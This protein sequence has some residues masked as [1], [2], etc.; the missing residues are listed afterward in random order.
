M[1]RT[2]VPASRARDYDAFLSYTRT[3]RRAAAGIQQS[4]HRI[5]RRLG[6]LRALRVFRD[7][8]DLTVSPDLWGKITDALDRSRFLVAVLSP[9]AAESY[10]VNREVS[11]WLE[12]GGRERLLLV[13]AGGRLQWDPEHQR[14]DPELS[15]AALPVLT[16]PEVLPAEPFFIDVSDNAP[17]NPHAATLREK[18]TAL[19][20][21][22]HGVPKDQLASDDL[23]ERQ[24]FR[25]LRAAAIAGMA[26]LTVMAVVAA[27]FAVVQQREAVHQRQQA[28]H[29][30]D[31]AVALKLTSQAQTMLAGIAPGGD[32]RAIQQILTAK[33]E[34][35]A[36]QMT[37]PSIGPAP[38]IHR[39][40]RV[41][42]Q[43]ESGVARSRWS[44]CR[45]GDTCDRAVD[46]ARQVMSR[47][48]HGS[49]GRHQ[50][51][52]TGK[53]LTQDPVGVGGVE[54][55]CRFVEQHDRRRGEQH[56]GQ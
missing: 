29:Q 46:I 44:S 9:K 17:W 28:L 3:D 19:A 38:R 2:P 32:V 8:T 37:Q 6:Q 23:R 11:Y 27:V 54:V 5:G 10:W 56:P 36:T 47:H 25:R 30:R 13:L 53:E 33:L 12:R 16:E 34:S 41:V 20:A 40:E 52:V 4:L 48:H 55:L 35:R 50:S 42:F 31:Q 15:N 14:F 43:I 45:A 51:G 7:D 49:G 26:V 24:R 1:P 22:I 21:P 39:N 18:V